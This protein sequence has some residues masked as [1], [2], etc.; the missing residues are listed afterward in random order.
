MY[1][2]LVRERVR[3][4]DSR[5]SCL[6]VSVDYWKEMAELEMETGEKKRLRNVPFQELFATWEMAE[7]EDSGPVADETAA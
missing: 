1:I 5:A 4:R 3:V 2:P 6:V 7:C